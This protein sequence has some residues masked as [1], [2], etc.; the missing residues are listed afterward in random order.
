MLRADLSLFP[1]Y[2]PGKSDDTKLKLSANEASFGPLPTALDAIR[3]AAARSNRYPISG[4]PVLRT[5]LAERLGLPEE[6]VAVTPG[7]SAVIQQAV[8]MT[9]SPGDE[10]LFPWRSFEAYPLYARVGGATPVQVP[11]GDGEAIDLDA[12]ADAITDRTRLI[13]ICNPNNPTGLTITKA[14]FAAFMQRVP[15][16][17]VVILDEAYYEFND[18][19]DTP[20]AVEEVGKYPNLIGARTFSKAYGLAGLRVGYGFGNPE[21]IRALGLVALPLTVT[22]LSELAAVASLA[23]HDELMVRVKETQAQRD[24]VSDVLGVH[25]S[26]GNF[27]WIPGSDGPDIER[28]IS[29]QGVIIRSYPDAGARVSITDETE[30]DQFLDAWRRAGLPTAR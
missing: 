20:D 15:E 14:E 12:V 25:R 17:V 5:A 21:L 4:S 26:R 13:I 23:A 22:E 19:E 27:V 10:V 2:K 7:A 28:K 9:C 11:L 3:D 1:D 6:H 29:D 16:D 8:F 30:T 24:R 18:A